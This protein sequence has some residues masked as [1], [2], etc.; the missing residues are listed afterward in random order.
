L[1]TVAAPDIDR[2]ALVT[3]NL[4][5]AAWCVNRYAPLRFREDP[6]LFDEMVQEARIGLMIAARKFDPARGVRFGTYA[7]WWCRQRIRRAAD[8][9]SLGVARVPVHVRGEDRLELLR[10][11]RGRS[12]HGPVPH[13][14][15]PDHW[16][17][18]ANSPGPAEL[19]AEADDRAYIHRCLRYLPRRQRRVIE[20]R[21]L[22]GA[23]LDQV[24]RELGITRERVRQLEERAL[25]R[26]R[27][28]RL[29]QREE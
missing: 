4:P 26:L 1:P 10:K 16:H 13:G 18:A 24:G 3:R 22:E 27:K 23:T 9:W 6:H 28:F 7:T 17:P 2:E 8:N 21:C 11:L 19:A 12:L 15:R 14:K 20:M 25:A 5:L 29:D